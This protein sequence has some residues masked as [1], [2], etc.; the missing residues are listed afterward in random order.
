MV[1]HTRKKN[2]KRKTRIERRRSIT[3]K[4]KSI[5]NCAVSTLY[6]KIEEHINEYDDIEEI[7]SNIGNGIKIIIEA[8]TNPGS[9]YVFGSANHGDKLFEVLDLI[10]PC[11]N[12]KQQYILDNSHYF[13]EKEYDFGEFKGRIDEEESFFPLDELCRLDP[14]CGRER[15][16]DAK[17]IDMSNKHWSNFIADHLT[18]N[19]VNFISVG[20]THLYENT[21]I[22]EDEEE[23]TNINKKIALPSFQNALH[24]KLPRKKI[25]SCIFV[26]F[27]DPS[28]IYNI[29]DANIIRPVPEL[30]KFIY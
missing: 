13:T 7:K 12:R 30:T 18:T 3:R 5:I 8:L 9:I 22:R 25:N 28:N 24:I 1:S 10:Y 4:L 14:P 15:E 26:N 17:R 23:W 16:Y 19:G 2:K 27:I 21:G 20:R 11:L 6:E 29:R